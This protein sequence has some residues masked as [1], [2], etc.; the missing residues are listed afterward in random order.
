MRGY[1][2]LGR[3]LT[4]TAC[5]TAWTG[6]SALAQTQ[7]NTTVKDA[8]EASVVRRAEPNQ[9]REILGPSEVL[10]PSRAWSTSVRN[11]VPLCAPGTIDDTVP[12][13]FSVDGETLIGQAGGSA[14]SQRCTDLAAQRADIQIR[15]DGLQNEPRLNVLA[16]PDAALK[17]DNVLFDTATNY[18]LR[19]VRGEVRIFDK[20]DTTR[21]TPLAVLPVNGDGRATWLVPREASDTL[22]YVYR[23]YDGQGRFDETS[24]KILDVAAVR[25][26]KFRSDEKNAV[27]DGNALSVRNIPKGGGAIL[28]SGR[29]I[30]PGSKV[31]VMGLPVRVDG[32]G[33]FAIR[34]FVGS[35]PQDISVIVTDAKG[36]KTEFV[37]SANIP[38]N[39]V[40]YVALAD[41]TVGHNNAA[42]SFGVLNPDRA[43]EYQDKVYVNGRLA[44]YLKGKIAGD[45]LLTASADTRDQPIRHLFS[46]FDS[47]DPRYLL[48]NLDPNKYYP[49]YGDDST[50]VEDAPTR[51]KFYVRL[52]R[53]DSNIVWGNFR[54]SVNGTEFVRYD[55]GLYGARAQAK[56][57]D[58]TRY[59][60][61]RGTAEGFVAE[62]GTM[63]GRDVL[64]GT[65][66]SLYY[67][68]R[69]N[70]AQGS[71]SITVEVRDDVTGLVLK[72]RTLTPVTDYEIDYLQG[73]VMLRSALASTGDDGMAV[74][75]GTL[76]GNQQYIVIN[77]EYSPDLTA[78]KDRVVGGRVSYW[79]NDH[80]EAGVTGYDQSHTAE[81]QR[82]GGA[83]VT[84]RYK[85]GT[86]VKVEGARSQGPG[87]GE[88]YSA[89]G[90]YTFS[91]R[92]TNGAPAWAKR[93]EA[94][95]DLSEFIR[96]ADGR[97][98]GYWK[99]KDR[100]FS[101]PGELAINGR[102]REMGI[103][104]DVK[105]TDRW[106]AKTKLDDTT[107]QYRH[108]AAGEQNV[109]YTFND[110]WKATLGARIDN[111]QVKEASASPALNQYGR[112]T[113]AVVRLDY[114]SH[115]D[116]GTYVFGQATL[117]RSGERDANN[118]V[119]VGGNLRLNERTKLTAEVSTGNLGLGGQIGAEYKIDEKRISYLNFGYSPDRTDIINRSGA[120]ILTSG[121]RERFTD[122]FS[123]FGEE[124]V[125]YGGGYSG[126]TH[127]FGL[128]FVPYDRWKT[129]LMFETGELS[130]PIQGDVKRT[131]ISPSIGYSRD[132][133]TYAGRFEYRHDDITTVGAPAA[134]AR[135][136]RDTY[137]VTNTLSNKLNPDWR[138]I[139][140]INGSYSDTTLG[141]Y[142]QGN[143]LEAVSGFAYRPI[144]ND[145]LN[146][147]FKY[148]FF[149]DLPSPGQVTL[150]GST[151]NQYAQQTHV[152]SADAA[153]DVT[154]LITVGGKVG[155]RLGEMRDTTIK[156]SGWM[157][158]DALLMIARV[159]LHVISE[160][161]VSAEVR[162]L[163]AYAASNS[164]TGALVA[165]YRHV[166]D[167][168][169]VGVG[170]NFT[171]YTDDLTNLGGDNKGIFLNAIGKF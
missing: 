91:N 2:R 46:N 29:D 30:A 103:R 142:Y 4:G 53:G 104:S 170:Y 118:R 68:S 162:T 120:G 107:D 12:F 59:G 144:Y 109:S 9:E 28:V 137:L 78:T 171:R 54:T 152:L 90:G 149:Y 61:R 40:F 127:A 148:T 123:V 111:N 27:Y 89:D 93:V 98:A 139:G 163:Q 160:W 72:T 105:L 82:I 55:R 122:S 49:V 20:A 128:D 157:T 75:T 117:D 166:G 11:A 95:A 102:T 108:Y 33:S 133:L 41:L 116:W 63:N 151:A 155:W 84:L 76:S 39:D 101:G 37:R 165:V 16:T 87:S 115:R 156:N 129:G 19:I 83:D 169:K 65:G 134:T 130:D 94:A 60:E 32:Q 81:S 150:N 24:V 131:A 141:T 168:F 70:I 17:G 96:G 42:K 135:S 47:K 113:D 18:A 74:R 52:E 77:Y 147:L 10:G 48:R 119:G 138:F 100:D 158:S 73:R 36:R 97:I 14:N 26:G 99:D 136:V 121:V 161:D 85:P 79:V 126:L 45:T 154:P 38:E 146:A 50:L 159:D 143:F 22:K 7:W 71:E 69:Q 145:R 125:R 67:L 56:T 112:R 8:W 114:D 1:A 57:A 25:G 34:Q 110:Y 124:R 13:N 43:D 167:N 51:G 86:Y 3:L 35:G 153:Y 164:E 58:Q 64:R 44:F 106:S 62:P 6:T 80:I 140:K 88:Q 23:V 92:T 15:Y 5:L 132:G 66:G 31:A 21:Q